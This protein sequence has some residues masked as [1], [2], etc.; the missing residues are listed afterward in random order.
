MKGWQRWRQWQQCLGLALS[1]CA[2]VLMIGADSARAQQSEENGNGLS[3]LVGIGPS[4]R[5]DYEG[6]EDYEPLIAGMAQLNWDDGKYVHLRS[7]EGS[8]AAPRMEANLVPDSPVI[9][10]PLI[11]YRLKRGDVDNSQVDNLSSVGGAL[12]MGVFLGIK[13][14]DWTIRSSTATDVSSRHHGTLVSLALKWSRAFTEHLSLGAELQSTWASNAYMGSY[15]SVGLVNS[16]RS[17]LDEYDADAGFKDVGGSLF[18]M[19]GMEDWEHLRIAGKFS[20][21]RL[22]GDAEDSPVVDDAGS[23]D[24]LF[25][26]L[27]LVWAQ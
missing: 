26:G 21:F 8:G 27:M 15:F 6:S 16:I 23:P 13:E 4:F 24:Q 17:D 14:G 1:V 12:E 18:A 20:Y 2:C 10:G 7:A 25:G 22:I 19:W 3:W 9:F 11:Q 5:P